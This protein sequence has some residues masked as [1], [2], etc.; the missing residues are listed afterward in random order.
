MQAPSHSRWGKRVSFQR[1]IEMFLFSYFR[2]NEFSL[3][4]SAMLL[5]QAAR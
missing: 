1:V 4:L 3:Y 5:A 2:A